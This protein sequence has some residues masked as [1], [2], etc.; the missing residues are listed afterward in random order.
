MS[1]HGS[2]LI[3]YFHFIQDSSICT[4]RFTAT[5]QFFQGD[6]LQ[7]YTLSAMVRVDC[8]SG[9]LTPV[10][11]GARMFAAILNYEKRARMAAVTLQC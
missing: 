6:S 7:N 3:S 10:F 9:E 2:K 1:V 8:N 5:Q 11:G 4:Y